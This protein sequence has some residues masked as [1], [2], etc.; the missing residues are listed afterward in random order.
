MSS[1]E[2][3][4]PIGSEEEALA[5]SAAL[6]SGPFAER[7]SGYDQ[8]RSF[9]FENYADLHEA[10]LL[11]LTVPRRYGG[12]EVSW[13]TYLGV[14]RTIGRACGSTCSFVT[15]AGSGGPGRR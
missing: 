6:A 10:G 14:L 12:A 8:S 7:A 11:A 5:A 13:A 9:P 3:R 4:T 15:Q 1:G 2:A